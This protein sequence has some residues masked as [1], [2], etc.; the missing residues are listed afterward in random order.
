M[1]NRRGLA[2]T[3][4]LF[5][6]LL[7]RGPML[8]RPYA[9]K[10]KCLYPSRRLYD[11]GGV[12]AKAWE[13]LTLANRFLPCFSWSHFIILSLG[14][15]Y[16]SKGQNHSL[17]HRERVSRY[18]VQSGINTVQSN[19]EQLLYFKEPKFCFPFTEFQSQLLYFI[20]LFK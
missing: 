5:K 10:D 20:I 2:I 11:Q 15:G 14:A 17:P 1:H 8:L 4:I 7:G 16:A 13:Y 12:Q 6:I 9:P 3:G 18:M 19:M